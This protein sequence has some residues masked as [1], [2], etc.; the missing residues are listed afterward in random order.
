MRRQAEGDGA[1][2]EESAPQLVDRGGIRE[3]VF[4]KSRQT[5]GQRFG[6]TKRRP[7]SSSGSP[8]A[9]SRFTK[10]ASFRSGLVLV[11]TSDVQTAY[12]P[13]AM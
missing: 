8:G 10:K 5:E 13:S 11:F 2:G 4:A 6:P 9:R 12:R 1:R 3:D 7:D